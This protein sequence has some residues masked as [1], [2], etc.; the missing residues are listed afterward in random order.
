MI[1]DDVSNLS[2]TKSNQQRPCI[3]NYYVGK[4]SFK[5]DGLVEINIEWEKN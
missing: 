1:M 4:G 3:N 5:T 2:E